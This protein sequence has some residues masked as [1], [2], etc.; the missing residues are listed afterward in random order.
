MRLVCDGANRRG[1]PPWCG[2]L[3]PIPRRTG[4]PK[5][6]EGQ[7]VREN[8]PHME[9]KPKNTKKIKFRKEMCTSADTK[10]ARTYA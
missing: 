6:K 8:R 1:A 4:G 5:Q 3:T 10:I 9:I 7:Q 2:C